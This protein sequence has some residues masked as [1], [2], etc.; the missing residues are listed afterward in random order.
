MS[1]TEGT[2]GAVEERPPPA[3]RPRVIS[4]VPSRVDRWFNRVTLAG[5]ITVL[6]LLTLVGLFLLLRSRD[7]LSETGLWKFLT[8]EEWRTDVNP[9][10][11]GVLGLLTGT[12]LVALVA[13]VDRRA[14]RHAGRA[15]H[16]RVLRRADAPAG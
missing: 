15:L 6:V 5:G 9:P 14:V 12:V 13:I 3:L 4:D 8:R 11:I 1:A 16:H 7:A 10:R 2:L